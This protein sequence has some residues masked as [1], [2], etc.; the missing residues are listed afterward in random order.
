MNPDDPYDLKRFLSAQEGIYERA[1]R[2]AY[3]WSKA[4]S[5]DVVYISAVRWIGVQSNGDAI[6]NQEHRRGSAVP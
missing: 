5:L 2:R 1:P 6:L 3:A 4:D